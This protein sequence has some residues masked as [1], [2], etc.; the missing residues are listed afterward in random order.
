MPVEVAVA[1]R[2]SAAVLLTTAQLFTLPPL[3]GGGSGE[4]RLRRKGLH[5]N[6]RPSHTVR[7]TKA[8][9]I[10]HIPKAAKVTS[11]KRGSSGCGVDAA[12]RK[13]VVSFPLAVCP[14]AH[15]PVDWK[16]P[17]SAETSGSK[18]EKQATANKARAPHRRTRVTL[19]PKV[20]LQQVKLQQVTSVL[21]FAQSLKFFRHKPKRKWRF[22]KFHERTG[23]DEGC[24]FGD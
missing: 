3:A 8:G 2:V 10:E 12:N 11:S 24:C 23:V 22:Y 19:K 14:P 6:S 17:A 15:V 9:H 7:Q 18:S 1:P 21:S 16:P 13:R 20:K 5:F 4:N